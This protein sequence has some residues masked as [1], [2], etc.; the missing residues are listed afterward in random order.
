M[1]LIAPDVARYSVWATYGGRNV[2]NV[3]D[4]RITDITLGM[5]R[6]T[7]VLDQA[8]WI[9]SQWRTDC[10]VDLCNEYQFQRVSWVDLDSETGSTGFVTSGNGVTLP[11][12]GGVSEAG[13]PGNVSMLIAKVAPGGG[14]RT[15]NGRT[16]VPGLSE[17]STAD[18]VPNT[19]SGGTVTQWTANM[20]AFSSG[21][22]RTVV[23]DGYSSNMVVVHT[24][25]E[26]TGEDREL[27][28]DGYS[29]V[30]SLTAQAT[31]ATQR[32]RIRG[33]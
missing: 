27:V 12:S 20:E 10:V 3:F 8:E 11:Q 7:A 33:R 2:A 28:Y 15:R 31:L 5:T 32:C 22:S 23:S 17:L 19:W 30:Q 18:N 14:R 29:E 9:L 16:Y 13:M 24:H 21:I 25:Y 1:P 4:M 6:D 26:G